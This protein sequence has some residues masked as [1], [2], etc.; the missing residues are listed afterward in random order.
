MSSW[1]L[2]LPFIFLPGHRAAALLMFAGALPLLLRPVAALHNNKHNKPRAI[3]GPHV[4]F[5][6]ITLI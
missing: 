6:D 1:L 4:I 3:K 5:M 2:F